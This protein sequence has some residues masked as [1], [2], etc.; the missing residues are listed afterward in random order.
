MKILY[1][2]G[3]NSTHR[4]FNFLKTKLREHEALYFEYDTHKPCQSNIVLAQNIV[5]G[6]EPDAIIGHS[7]GGVITAYLHTTAKRVAIAS[8]FAGSAL[9]NWFPMY[10]QLMRDV[11]T[12]SS[13]IRGIRGKE[14]DPDRF[15][16]IVAN[17]LD[18]N[19]FDGVITSRSQMALSGASYLSYNLNH[20]EVMVDFDVAEQINEFIA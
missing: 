8:P 5:D 1:I 4:S 15:L 7:L 19:G 18:G 9:A 12:T 17:G 13:L 16:A 20:F 3:A 11:A 10:S 2:H 14:V 6:C